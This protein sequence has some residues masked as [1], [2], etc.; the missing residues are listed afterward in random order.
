MKQDMKRTA[1][2]SWLAG[3]LGLALGGAFFYAGLQKRLEPY[4]FAEAILAYQFLPQ[5]LVGLTAAVLPWLE[6]ASGFF[7]ALGYLVEIP[8]RLLQGLGVS[9]GDRLVGGIKRRSCLILIMLQLVVILVVLAITFARGLKIDCGCGL[10]WARQVGWGIILEDVLFLGLTG[11]LYWWALPGEEEPH[12]ESRRR[13]DDFSGAYNGLSNFAPAQV[14]L[15][16]VSYPTVEHAYQAAKNLEP[17]MRES[18]RAASTPELAR[19][20]G[21]KLAQRPD[22]PEVRVEV[23]RD[24]VRQKFSGRPD[25]KVV[26][27]ATGDAELV[28]GNTWHDNFWGR[29]RCSRCVATPGLNWLGRILMEVR[30][31]LGK[32]GSS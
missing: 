24:L 16:G 30:E 5:P 2:V 22:W 31:G 13:I 18:I 1:A 28:E 23:M 4:Q 26:L 11:L 9:L 32:E 12:W 20:M 10:F 27:L 17:E 8:G 6:M 14:T 7:L 25:L 21:R 3:V 19:K 15:D 29:C